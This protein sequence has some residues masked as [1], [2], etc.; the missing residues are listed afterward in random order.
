MVCY[1]VSPEIKTPVWKKILRFFKLM[2]KRE[3]FNLL[4]DGDYFK[5]KDIVKTPE[6][7]EFIILKRII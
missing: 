7:S 5:I 3:E 1:T 4:L 2:K 6:G